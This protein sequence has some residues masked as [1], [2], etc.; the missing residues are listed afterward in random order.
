MGITNE[1]VEYICSKVDCPNIME[2]IMSNPHLP[3]GTITNEG[4]LHISRMR[5]D[6]LIKL[7]LGK[8]Y[9]I[10]AKMTLVIKGV[11]TSPRPICPTWNSFI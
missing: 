2:I 4:V 1:E 10:K 5:W 7:N 9:L 11:N 3:H 6:S 8:H